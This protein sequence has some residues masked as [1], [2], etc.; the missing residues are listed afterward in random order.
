M[1]GKEVRIY[2]DVCKV[3]GVAPRS[4]EAFDA[5]VKYIQALSWSPAAESV[6]KCAGT[7]NL[8]QMPAGIKA[9]TCGVDVQ[10]RRL[11][12]AVRGWGFSMESWLI[13]YGEILGEADDLATWAELGLLLERE[14]G[15]AEHRAG[16]RIRRM[17]IDSGY[18]PGDKWRRPD[19]LVYDFCLRNPR[20]VPTKGRDRLSKP[21]Q[22]SL[23]D[24]TFRGQVHKQ[25]LRLWHIDSD[26]FKSWVQNRL[27]WPAEQ[28]GHW[29]VPQDVTDDYCLQLTAEA[30]VPKPSGLATWV[31]I[32]AENHLLDCEAINVAMAQSLGFHRRVRGSKTAEPIEAAAAEV[33]AQMPRQPSEPTTRAQRPRPFRTRNWTTQW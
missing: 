12:Y 8:G 13:D 31:K 33:P 26:Y 29:W 20:A 14:Y 23:I 3:I 1:L 6:R 25:G 10:K 7:Y 16:L 2:E 5:R 30:R 32:R 19:N 24:V 15:A 11:V 27:E 4:F 18:R 21:L 17:G 28:A 9:L 22:P